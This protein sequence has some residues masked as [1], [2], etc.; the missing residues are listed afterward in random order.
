MKEKFVFDGLD[1]D[2][3]EI[4]EMTVINDTGVD[5][6]RI[7]ERVMS[8]IRTNTKGRKKGAK[9]KL[10]VTLIAAAAAVTVLGTVTAGATGSFNGVFGQMFSGE[11]ADGMYA[12]GNVN[13]S[14]SIMDVDFK[15]IAGDNEEVY[16]L[17]TMKKTDGSKIFEGDPDNCFAVREDDKPD[18][19]CT[20]SLLD[21]MSAKLFYHANS[22]E[23]DIEYVVTDNYT[24]EALVS[25]NDTEFNIIGETLSFNDD[26]F[27]IYQV[28]KVLMSADEIRRTYQE[29]SDENDPYWADGL[30]VVEKLERDIKT[31]SDDQVVNYDHKGN[32]SLMTRTVV[33]I[34]IHGSVKLNYRN[35]SRSFK[36]AEGI[37]TTYSG[38]DVTVTSLEIRPFSV[39]IGL[40]YP[41][42]DVDELADINMKESPDAEN[43]VTV[44]L[45]DGKTYSSSDT[46]FFMS[47]NNL[48]LTYKFYG[49]TSRAVI[50]P[51]QVSSVV[52]NGTTLYQAK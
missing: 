11:A 30:S 17:M 52:Y 22:G 12:G 3:K 6:E 29:H 28:D 21:Q 49:E 18:V 50:D 9:R 48:R 15:G 33:D 41:T 46:P 13:I 45:R 27:V 25:Y 5:T 23:G 37:K 39:R 32:I 2:I 8:T 35:T 42:S 51:E 10:G 26:N 20:R 16:G 7:S 40:V 31:K 1:D 36:E 44:T 43:T 38:S 14:S 47:D 24:V 34:D 4:D 19:S